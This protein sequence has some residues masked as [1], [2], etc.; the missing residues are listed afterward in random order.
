LPYRNLWKKSRIGIIGAGQSAKINVEAIKKVKLCE[1]VSLA[2]PST[3]QGKTLANEFGVKYYQD[4][5]DMIIKENLDLVIITTPH[6]LHYEMCL[7]AMQHRKHVLLEKTMT[8][9]VAEAKNL[10]KEQ[11]KNKVK[12]GIILQLRA[13]PDAILAKN[14]VDGGKIGKLILISAY[15]KH[16]R[17]NKYYKSWKGKRVYAGGGTLFNQGIHGLD[18]MLWFGGSV[19]ECVGLYDNLAHKNT[20]VEDTAAAILKF[21]S[22][23]LGVI[24]STTSV[25][26]SIPQK[27]VVQGTKGTLV[28]EGTEIPRIT[29]FETVNKRKIKVNIFNEKFTKKNDYLGPGHEIILKDFLEA[30]HT[31][32]DPV[33]TPESAMESVELA[34]LIYQSGKKR[35]F[36]NVN[37]K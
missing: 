23:T 28:L 19:S 3:K 2:S 22:G 33:I 21:K 26:P 31:D 10:I 5:K 30:I 17:T 9:S 37:L 24:E 18:L 27:I 7:F 15:C 25:Y 4:Y 1:L 34:N 8:L 11:N 14:I 13:F 32:S 35:K 12:L 29:S 36:V 6:Y 20:D 16:F